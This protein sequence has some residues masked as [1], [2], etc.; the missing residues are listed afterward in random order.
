MIDKTIL[1]SEEKAVL[2][3]RSLYC[4]YGYLPY[5]MSKFEEYELYI[6]NKDFLVSDR[7]ITFNDTSGRLMALKPDVTLSIIKNCEDIPGF[8]QKVYYDEH[9]YRVSDR[10]ERFCELMQTGC[11]C[12]GDIDMY[13]IYEII[14]LAAESLRLISDDYV[15]E[16]SCLDLIEKWISRACGDEEFAEK[17]LRCIAEKNAHDLSRLCAR[18]RV[19]RPDETRLLLLISAY[20]ERNAVIAALAQECAPDDLTGLKALSALLDRSPCGDKIRFDFSVVN[21]MGYYN[22]FVFR[23]FLSGVSDGVLSGGQ[24]DRLMKKMN[25]QSKAI[26]FAIYLDELEQL[27]GEDSRFDV[28]VLV[29]YDDSV[30]AEDVAAAVAA[31]AALGRSVSAQKAADSRLRY[32]EA[33]DLRR[34]DVKSC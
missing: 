34:E 27:R 29:L 18:Y 22:G 7:I 8:K 9:V 5:R 16:V 11:E 12:I 32:R 21:N 31:N 20:G 19:S 6:R 4:R 14:G 26:G 10:T 15:L 25:R 28:D 2:A 33:V 24:Y 30:R 1:K 3:L 17:A 13:D 23:G